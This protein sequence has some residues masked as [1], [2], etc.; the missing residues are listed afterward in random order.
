MKWAKFHG[1]RSRVK[2]HVSLDVDNNQPV[3]IEE[4]IAIKYDAPI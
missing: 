4:T 2:L 3:Q 1:K